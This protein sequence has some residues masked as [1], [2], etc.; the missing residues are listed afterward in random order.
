MKTVIPLGGIILCN[1]EHRIRAAV[2]FLVGAALFHT[3]RIAPDHP[4]NRF[5]LITGDSI[6]LR[7]LSA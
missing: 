3:A 2:K 7:S 6:L 4:V 5:D 1:S